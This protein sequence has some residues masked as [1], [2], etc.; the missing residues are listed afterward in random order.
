LAEAE[1]DMGEERNCVASTE[2]HDKKEKSDKEKRSWQH[3]T[4]TAIDPIKRVRTGTLLNTLL[5]IF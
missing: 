3:Q 4:S 1:A 5:H 2:T